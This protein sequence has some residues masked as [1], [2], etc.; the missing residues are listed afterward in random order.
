MLRGGGGG[1][2]TLG[3]RCFGACS[4]CFTFSTAAWAASLDDGSVAL[5]SSSSDA[6]PTLRCSVL[7]RLVAFDVGEVDSDD[8]ERVGGGG[9]GMAAV[10]DGVS[11]TAAGF[12]LK[13]LRPGLMSA[14]SANESTTTVLAELTGSAEPVLVLAAGTGNGVPDSAA[15]FATIAASLADTG[16]LTAVGDDG[17]GVAAAFVVVAVVVVVGV[18]N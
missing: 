12:F 17:D 15:F 11:T 10:S 4:A 9:G 5:S 6:G 2:A 16:G 3:P 8:D 1:R 14:S 13:T 18:S 7:S